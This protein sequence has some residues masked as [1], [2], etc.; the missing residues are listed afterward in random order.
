MAR[1][2]KS[3][4]LVI[5][6]DSCQLGDR[7]AYDPTLAR[8]VGSLLRPASL[9]LPTIYCPTCLPCLP[10]EPWLAGLPC[11][12]TCMPGCLLLLGLFAAL[13]IA[14]PAVHPCLYV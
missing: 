8:W 13:V 10:W 14:H 1:V 11:L 2:C 6:T 12:P 4:G 5:L 9:T 7:L 3:G